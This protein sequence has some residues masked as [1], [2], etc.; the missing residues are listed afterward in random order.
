LSCGPQGRLLERIVPERESAREETIYLFYPF[1]LSDQLSRSRDAQHLG[2]NIFMPL[3]Y[4][5]KS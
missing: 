5:S 3:L 2:N 1:E 4:F